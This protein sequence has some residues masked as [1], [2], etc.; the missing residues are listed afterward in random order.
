M[1]NLSSLRPMQCRSEHRKGPEGVG[2]APS[3]AALTWILCSPAPIEPRS[4]CRRCCGWRFFCSFPTRFFSVTA[5]GRFRRRKRS[6][7]PGRWTTTA[8]SSQVNVYWQTL[9]RSMW[10]AARVT[11]FS[12]LLGYPLAYYLSFHAG[13][14]KDLSLSV[15]DYS[16]V[17]QLPGARLRVEDHPGQR[18]RPQ[19][20]CC[21]MC[22]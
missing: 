4:P 6:S 17:G 10:I 11:I 18:W 22:I 19:Y 15:G 1:W 21:N 13:K 16:A 8:N 20:A 3:P 7:T 12:L 2:R 5:S 14:R 9:L